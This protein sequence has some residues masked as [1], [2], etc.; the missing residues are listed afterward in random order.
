MKNSFYSICGICSALSA[1]FPAF[2]QAQ[3]LPLPDHI[4]IVIE[5]NHAYQKIIGSSA[6][7]YINQLADSGA[8]FT[9]SY[10]LTHPSQPNY[11]M[12]YS[13]SNQGISGTLFGDTYPTSTPWSMTLPFNTRNMGACLIAKG[14]TFTGYAE[15]LPSVGFLGATS[16]NYA[17][18]HAV[19]SY[20]QGTGANHIPSAS[21]Q[22]LTSFPT[23]FAN[24]PTVSYVIPNLNDDMHNGTDPATITT[25]DT[26]LQNH[27]DAY[28]QWAKT[29]NSLFILTF[30]EDDNSHS[31]LI[32][33]IFTGQM[34]KKG[35]Y[36]ET[37]NHYNILRTL[38]DIYGICHDANDSTVTAITDCWISTSTAVNELQSSVLDFQVYPNLTSGIFNLKMSLPIA[39]GIENVQIKLYNIYGECIHQLIGK[40]EDQQIDLSSQPNG[41]YFLKLQSENNSL[42]KKIIIVH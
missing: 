15:G 36:S 18:K 20:W 31:N 22:P 26:W 34:V 42:S 4:V 27:L 40:S 7:P 24:L 9:Q 35:Q 33:T 11:L 8:L 14:N 41:I 5:E 29:H 2:L 3:T 10:A 12:L 23:N 39:I 17:S 21:N 19:Y 30:D 38:E 25:G 37:I 13:G 28:I 6:A 1:G 32:A 16:G